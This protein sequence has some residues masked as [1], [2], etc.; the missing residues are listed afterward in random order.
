MT[1]LRWTS[2]R[3]VNGDE[4]SVSNLAALGVELLSAKG[5]TVY[6]VDDEVG[7]V[8]KMGTI[9]VYAD[10]RITVLPFEDV[11]QSAVDMLLGVALELFRGERSAKGWRVVRRGGVTRRICGWW[12][13]AEA[14]DPVSRM[15]ARQGRPA[16]WWNEA[17]R[18][19]ILEE[20]I[21]NE[22][23]ARA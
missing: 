6:Q 13:R 12:C 3:S 7:V 19:A 8:M 2:V 5:K 10:G 11:P 1:D 15:M 14:E 16:P 23:H 22:R 18:H 17:D 20:E 21:E 4:L 9:A